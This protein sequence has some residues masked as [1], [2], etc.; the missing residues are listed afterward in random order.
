MLFE[1][2]DLRKKIKK[3]ISVT[4]W[5]AFTI[6]FLL[7]GVVAVAQTSVPGDQTY[8]IKQG[9]EKT[10]LAGFSLFNLDSRYQIDLTELRFE[11]TKKIIK[12]E[13]A[14]L[15]FEKLFEQMISAEY[16]IYAVKDPK[17]KA[18]LANQYISTLTNISYQLEQEKKIYT[19]KT[20]L[21][22]AGRSVALVPTTQNQPPLVTTSST[23][24]NQI[25]YTQEQIQE[26][27]NRLNTIAEQ[28]Q[29]ETQDDTPWRPTATPITVPTSPPPTAIP[30]IPLY[31][32]QG[33][34]AALEPAKPREDNSSPPITLTPT[35]VVEP[36]ITPLE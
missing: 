10:V 34:G 6:S 15:G 19:E 20:T 13:R 14:Y 30:T 24:T 31:D 11:E 3:I 7:A 28:Q 17:K 1:E 29:Q 33:G 5:I 18:N 9:F 32:K 36:T 23:V 12:T 8:P 2:S 16:S 25:N 4:T 26:L 21:P 27:I 22:P 35:P